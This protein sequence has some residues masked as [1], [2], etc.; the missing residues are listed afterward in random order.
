MIQVFAVEMTAGG[1]GE[2]LSYLHAV[3]LRAVLVVPVVCCDRIYINSRSEGGA[4]VHNSDTVA[5]HLRT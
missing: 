1:G 3:Q 5:A 4:M 2:D